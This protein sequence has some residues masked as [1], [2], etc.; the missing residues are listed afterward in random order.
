MVKHCSANVEAM[1]SNPVGVTKVFSGFFAVPSI[2]IT[3]AMIISSFKF[4]PLKRA[5]GLFERGL[6]EVQRFKSMSDNFSRLS[7]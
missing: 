6:I 2:A 4:F 1:G 7:D 5:E 3:T